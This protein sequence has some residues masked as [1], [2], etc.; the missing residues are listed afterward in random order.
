[1][2]GAPLKG[3]IVIIDDVL[4]SG[5]S[6]TRLAL[7][8]LLTFFPCTESNQ[9]SDR[10]SQEPPGSGTRRHRPARGSSRAW[11]ARQRIHRARGREGVQRSRRLHHCARRYCQLHG[12]PGGHEGQAGADEGVPRT[13]GHHRAIVEQVVYH[14]TR[15]HGYKHSS[16]ACPPAVRPQPVSSVPNTLAP[17]PLK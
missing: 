3:K 4:T 13:V 8:G 17:S 12:E 14:H 2:V 7:Y 6:H 9:G 15:T 11:T 5:V 1:M 10:H 16:Y